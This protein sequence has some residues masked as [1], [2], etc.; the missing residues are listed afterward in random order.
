MI[1]SLGMQQIRDA[2]MRFALSLIVENDLYIPHDI[3]FLENTTFEGRRSGCG[4][5]ASA[6]NLRVRSH[7]EKKVE[8]LSCKTMQ[9]HISRRPSN[10]H[11]KDQFSSMSPCSV[12]AADLP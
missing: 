4:I 3:D 7:L 6:F 8:R 2:T 9:V 10:L 12:P 1:Y 11:W 5:R